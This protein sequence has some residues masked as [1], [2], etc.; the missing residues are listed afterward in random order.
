MPNE[1][2]KKY[3]S[4]ALSAFNGF[5]F[6]VY[7]TVFLDAFASIIL[8]TSIIVTLILFLVILLSVYYT[9]YRF[10]TIG[11]RLNIIIFCINIALLFAFS[12]QFT[13]Q[14]PRSIPSGS[15]NPRPSPGPS[16][17]EVSC[18]E[19]QGILTST[20]VPALRDT[21][22]T[23]STME[24]LLL[25]PYNSIRASSQLIL[26]SLNAAGYK[27]VSTYQ[28]DC[29]LMFVTAPEHILDDG[30]P[31]P[32][33]W[34]NSVSIKMASFSLSEYLRALLF[35][36]KARFRVITVFLTGKFAPPEDQNIQRQKLTV[37]YLHG[38]PGAP[39]LPNVTVRN[40][41]YCYVYIYEFYN[42]GQGEAFVKSSNITGYEHLKKSGV[43]A[44]LDYLEHI[45]Q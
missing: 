16:P 14:A 27:S 39:N 44:A 35:P 28:V 9:I 20:G 26:Q 4:L 29:G 45:S 34:S 30:Q 11:L 10:F 21:V 22:P 15:P 40:G 37:L 3:T 32:D 17:T 5:V 13:L 31:H 18:A 38:F 43:L 6:S 7:I 36:A 25:S 23:P 1:L 19:L 41:L 33:R 24:R 12:L 42:S 2:I 8:D